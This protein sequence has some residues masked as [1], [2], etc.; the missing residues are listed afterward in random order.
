MSN[1][2]E[3]L[4]AT[5]RF[6]EHTLKGVL[7]IAEA[8]GLQVRTGTIA[9]IASEKHNA[10]AL[11]DTIGFGVGVLPKDFIMTF[12]RVPLTVT[13][14]EDSAKCDIS[15]VSDF[16]QFY[17]RTKI[18]LESIEALVTFLDSLEQENDP[19]LQS[20]LNSLDDSSHALITGK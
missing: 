18:Q 1:T 17:H 12:T 2:F 9:C 3:K 4:Q 8:I 13:A 10:F 14:S 11:S 15:N 6:R 7:T 20:V 5:T 19:L 16:I